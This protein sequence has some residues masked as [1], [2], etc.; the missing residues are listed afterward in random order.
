MEGIFKNSAHLKRSSEL[1]WILRIILFQS[2]IYLIFIE[3]ELNICVF[4]F[5]ILSK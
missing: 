1:K 2:F 4:V 5:G 3:L